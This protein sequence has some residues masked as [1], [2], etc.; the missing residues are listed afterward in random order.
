MQACMQRHSWR[1][2]TENSC[3]AGISRDEGGG[4]GEWGGTSSC[5]DNQMG[6][7]IRQGSAAGGWCGVL[8]VCLGCLAG[9]HTGGSR[10]WAVQLHV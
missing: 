1:Q 8:G 2:L 6:G 4:E 9:S 7:H 10:G 5:T 3:S